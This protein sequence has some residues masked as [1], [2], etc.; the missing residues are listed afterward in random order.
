MGRRP[1]ADRWRGFTAHS[2]TL[3]PATS[4][5]PRTPIAPVPFG[6]HT[7]ADLLGNLVAEMA[8]R[9]HTARVICVHNAIARWPTDV[10]ICR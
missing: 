4:W 10:R 9:R 8:T 2:R 6:A 3:L 5:P 7:A 1:R